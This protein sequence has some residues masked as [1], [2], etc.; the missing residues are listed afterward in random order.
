MENV[1]CSPRKR[2]LNSLSP[3]FKDED[4]FSPLNLSKKSVDIPNRKTY[5]V[6]TSSDECKSTGS[7]ASG[8][9]EKNASVFGN[10]QNETVSSVSGCST[11]EEDGACDVI[12]VGSSPSKIPKISLT[13]AKKIR[14]QVK[15][16]QIERARKSNAECSASSGQ[17]TSFPATPTSLAC[18]D[19]GTETSSL[20]TTSAALSNKPISRLSLFRMKCQAKKP[21]TKENTT[22]GKIT[23][24][25]QIGYQLKTSTRVQ[26]LKTLTCPDIT[27]YVKNC[28]PNSEKH[29]PDLMSG[30]S[31]TMSGEEDTSILSLNYKSQNI[32]NVSS[33]SLKE[34][35]EF[36]MSLA[37]SSLSSAKNIKKSKKSP[38]KEDQAQALTN[39]QPHFPQ[40]KSAFR[41]NEHIPQNTD[42]VFNVTPSVN[43]NNSPSK[44]PKGK[45][46]VSNISTV[47]SLSS[48]QSA[49][50]HEQKCNPLPLKSVVVT[51]NLH[52]KERSPADL[53]QKEKSQLQPNI[54]GMKSVVGNKP[55]SRKNNDSSLNH[56]KQSVV[57]NRSTVPSAVLAAPALSS[58]SAVLNQKICNPVQVKSETVIS[59]DLDS[60]E[61]NGLKPPLSKP[62]SSNSNATVLATS[63]VKGKPIQKKGE[64][65][66]VVIDKIKGNIIKDLSLNNSVRDMSS[67]MNILS[68]KSASVD[69]CEPCLTIQQSGSQSKISKCVRKNEKSSS[70]MNKEETANQSS[71]CNVTD[72]KP[73]NKLSN[74]E[75]KSPLTVRKDIFLDEKECRKT[76]LTKSS[77]TAVT[78]GQKPLIPDMNHS[79][80]EKERAESY[81][82]ELSPGEKSD[83][84]PGMPVIASYIPILFS[85][86]KTS[87][88]KVS[89]GTESRALSKQNTDIA[90]EVFIRQNVSISVIGDGVNNTKGKQNENDILRNNLSILQKSNT[91]C[92]SMTEI[93]QKN[94]SV[95]NKSTKQNQDLSAAL[96]SSSTVH[97]TFQSSRSPK[98]LTPTSSSVTC[99]ASTDEHSVSGTLNARCGALQKV[100]KCRAE[101]STHTSINEGQLK[102]SS[103]RKTGF[104]SF[105][106]SPSRNSSATSKKQSMS[107]KVEKQERE[108]VSIVNNIST[109]VSSSELS[110]LEIKSCTDDM[111]T[112]DDI[113]TKE[114]LISESTRIEMETSI[115]S[116][117][118]KKTTPPVQ[119]QPSTSQNYVVSPQI[120][121]HPKKFSIPD[122][123]NG[124]EILM[125][126][127]KMNSPSKRLGKNSPIKYVVNNKRSP[128]KWRQKSVS[129]RKDGVKRSLTFDVG[130]NSIEEQND[131]SMS[132]LRFSTECV[133]YF[134][135]VLNEVFQDADMKKVISETES[136]HV[137][138]FKQLQYQAKKLYVRMLSRKYTWHRVTDIKYNEIDVSAAFNDLEQDGFVTS[139]YNSEE[140][141]VLLNMLKLQE[142]KSLCKTF[143]IQPITQ[144]KPILVQALLDYG[145]NQ[146]TL[147]GSRSDSSLVLRRRLRDELRHCIKL[148]EKQRKTFR[149]IFLLFSLP[150]QNTNEDR[151]VSR[152]LILLHYVKTNKIIFPSFSIQKTRPVFQTRDA[153]SS[154]E[155]ANELLDQM[156]NALTAKD[157]K[158]AQLCGQRAWEDFKNLIND[159]VLREEAMRM[160]L[161]MRSYTAASTYAYVMTQAVDVF[162]KGK[163]LF[164]CVTMLQELLSQDVYLLHYRG[165]WYDQLALI[166]QS[167]LKNNAEAAE[168]VIRGME[169]PDVG[170]VD[171]QILSTRG[172]LLLSRRKGLS[173]DLKLRLV[174]LIKKPLRDPPSVLIKA[175]SLQSNAPGRKQVYV[176][177]DVIRQETTYSSVEE[178]AISHYHRQG[179]KEGMHAEG[180]VIVTLFGLIFW[181]VIYG[182]PLPDVY[183]S[184]YQAEPLDLNSVEFYRNRKE[185][186]D[187]RLLDLRS[188]NLETVNQHI[189]TIFEQHEEKISIVSWQRF[190]SPQ[191]VV[192][193][194]NSI[195]VELLSKILERL[196]KHYRTVRSGFPDLFVWD[197]QRA[198]CKFVE[199]KGPNDRLSIPQKMWLNY[200]TKCN[201]DAEVCYVE[202]TGSKRCKRKK[203]VAESEDEDDDI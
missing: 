30:S 163:L 185:V 20:N 71:L 56:H 32:E 96:P 179:Y 55:T 4:C 167:H 180:S 39:L 42:K 188:W 45:S 193:V 40:I 11:S 149:R 69:G 168:T 201:A 115:S 33:W 190:R 142:L 196:A 92:K 171:Q 129:P 29:A 41:E 91:P 175:K 8:T 97:N 88:H 70:S 83:L 162:K 81:R 146:Q 177:E 150:H 152:Q 21:N 38:M 17:S 116:P 125:A 44:S 135:S 164:D 131:N 192:E 101:E 157:W 64:V 153:M 37:S 145:R 186:I 137:I 67:E 34:K 52:S 61:K 15:K 1:K 72:L 161:Y 78:F 172:S 107:R 155:D 114:V 156:T 119:P 79:S 87:E 68:C 194:I 181:D 138:K 126:N 35:I 106:P 85:G 141:D 136:N 184:P 127:R 134:E 14:R 183:R 140:L 36:A 148:C 90:T 93:R 166:L 62:S 47:P 98:K 43:S 57:G 63:S 133:G 73:L 158:M 3:Q 182:H 7:C 46:R 104:L 165:K 113:S 24:D 123:K 13:D 76:E 124:F 197:P 198:K 105:V 48:S 151:D 22:I 31:T 108:S 84:L 16:L 89:N 66:N 132:S 19:S 191:Q 109:K 117:S 28:S 120:S 122:Q 170:E 176:Q 80:P 118:K 143:R 139:D 111:Y 26:E 200:L 27:E 77:E 59:S 102:Y 94:S 169:D 160:P 53:I 95:E 58:Q 110:R 12:Y 51:S 112:N 23:E 60:K 25:L 5:P 6:I 144:P 50:L 54:S 100:K 130:G 2:K 173:D 189:K 65:L 103:E 99:S 75:I 86:I 9:S 10:K 82:E 74:T 178:F 49:V 159:P 18:N 121:R 174:E 187:N 147:G 195:G 202:T 199:V 128:S 154:F 203:T